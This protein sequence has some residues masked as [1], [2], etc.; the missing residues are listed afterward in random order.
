MIIKKIFLQQGAIILE[1]LNILIF[2]L[3]QVVLKNS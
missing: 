2:F 3:K 1:I